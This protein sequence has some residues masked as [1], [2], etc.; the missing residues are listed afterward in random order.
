MAR[1]IEFEAETVLAPRLDFL[2][3]NVMSANCNHESHRCGSLN[4]HNT[5][6]IKFKIMKSKIRAKYFKLSD[7]NETLFGVIFH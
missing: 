2:K 6:A 3:C 5:N 7:F 1:V 4:Y